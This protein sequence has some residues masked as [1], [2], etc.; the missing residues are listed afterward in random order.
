MTLTEKLNAQLDAAKT[1]VQSDEFKER[2]IISLVLAAFIIG[3][4][5][6]GALAFLLLF[7]LVSPIAKLFNSS[8]QYT[9][10]NMAEIAMSLI[11][12]KGKGNAEIFS[13]LD[14]SE[15][16]RVSFMLVVVL[17]VGLIING[18]PSARSSPTCAPSSPPRPRPPASRPPPSASVRVTATQHPNS[19]AGRGAVLFLGGR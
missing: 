17:I 13:Q 19:L 6:L 2:S 14:P 4:L 3:A 11:T 1:Y 5:I 7:W 18:P 16:K 10:K 8:I 15:R 12:F 9:T